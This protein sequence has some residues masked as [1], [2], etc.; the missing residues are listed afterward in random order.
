MPDF[1]SF[2]ALGDSFTEGVGDPAAG[3]PAAGDP[4]GGQCR[5]WADR[6]AERLARHQPGTRYANLAVRG[7]LLGEVL[8]EQVPAATAM[9]PDLVSLAAGGNDLLRPLT[10]PDDVATAF[11]AAVAALTA[12]GCTVLVFTGFDPKAFPV[13]R[14]YRGRAALL[15][16][17]VR[18][19]AERHGC[20]LAD[21]WSMRILTDRRLWAPDRLHLCPDGHRRV[22]LLACEAAGVPASENWRAPLPAPS[23]SSWL[24]ARWQDVTWATEHAAPYLSRRLHGISAGDGRAPKRPELTFVDTRS[25]RRG[26]N[27]H[28][29][30][31]VRLAVHVD[32]GDRHGHARQQSAHD[33][34]ELSGRGD[35]MAGDR[36]QDVSRDD[37]GPVR[38]GA[39]ELADDER[40]RAGGGHLGRNAGVEVVG[41]ADRGA[42]PHREA[43]T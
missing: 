37:P 1:A 12:A 20:L 43:G 35:L 25:A 14:L 33:G 8:D 17:H 29:R 21:L 24:A 11:E 42:R 22:A 23:A 16:M 6:F 30:A 39:A 40:A 41:E 13:L 18:E 36:G 32:P 5:G 10:D 4:A 27:Q 28:Q 3:D 26:L 19:I 9:A 31:M 34:G 15:S 7:K 2:V 38:G